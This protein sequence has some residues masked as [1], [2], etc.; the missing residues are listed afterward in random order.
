MKSPSEF[1]VDDVKYNAKDKNL[2]VFEKLV[3]DL[4][5]ENKA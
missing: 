4:T 3:Q 5:I 2:K 1:D